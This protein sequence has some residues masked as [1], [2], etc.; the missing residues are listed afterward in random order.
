MTLSISDQPSQ[1]HRI[2]ARHSLLTDATIDPFPYR[3]S[4]AASLLDHHIVREPYKDVHTIVDDGRRNT[5]PYLPPAAS[6]IASHSGSPPPP[7][8]LPAPPDPR[9]P[10]PLVHPDQ[11]DDLDARKRSHQTMASHDH[12]EGSSSPTSIG[13]M[14]GSSSFCLCQPEPKIPRPRNGE[15]TWPNN[16]SVKL[17]KKISLHSLS[18]APTSSSG[19][20]ESWLA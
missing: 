12:S 16:S 4:R 2:T 19:S 13:H 5:V 3:T 17:T 14:D 6:H 7:Q 1:W 9:A 11:F 10:P 8:Q 18:P 15:L 20:C